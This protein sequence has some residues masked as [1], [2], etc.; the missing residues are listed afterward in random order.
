MCGC[1][2]GAAGIDRAVV[3]GRGVVDLEL[4]PGARSRVYSPVKRV[5][6][7]AFH[8]DQHDAVLD[9]NLDGIVLGIPFELGRQ[10]L[11]RH[12]TIDAQ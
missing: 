8:V 12:L 7:D 9:H 5:L 6:V 10:R 3:R 2:L 11:G 1:V 4:K